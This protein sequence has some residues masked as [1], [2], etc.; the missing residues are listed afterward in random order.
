[1]RRWLFLLCFLAACAPVPDGRPVPEPPNKFLADPLFCNTDA[2][3]TCGGVD[4]QTGECFLGN[5]LYFSKYVDMEQRC[6]D[7]CSGIAGDLEIRCVE[8]QCAQVE[9][10]VACP[11]DAKVCPDGTVVVRTGP[12]CTFEPCPEASESNVSG[13]GAE[14][15]TDADCVPA[16]CCHPTA[17]VPASE[18]PSCDDVMCTMECKPGTLDC[19][20]SCGCVEGQCVGRNYVE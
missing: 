14:C 15:K 19:G 12:E 1:M 17:C 9:R 18:A 16:Q 6:A 7:F 10:Q 8:N 5:K 13:N 4:T 3:C 11:Q 2:D 20:G